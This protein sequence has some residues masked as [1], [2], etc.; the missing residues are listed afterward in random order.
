[1]V[2]ATRVAHR[3][4]RRPDADTRRVRRLHEVSTAVYRTEPWQFKRVLA[5]IEHCTAREF[6]REVFD[7]HRGAHRVFTA[8]AFLAAYLL[9][10]PM[11]GIALHQTNVTAVVRGWTTSQRRSLGLPPPCGHH[12]QERQRCAASPAVG[13]PIVPLSAVGRTRLRAGSPRCVPVV[14]SADRCRRPGFD[15]HF[16]VGEGSVPQTARRRRPR[17]GGATARSSAGAPRTRSIPPMPVAAGIISRTRR[18]ARTSGTSTRS[19]SPLEWAGVVPS[20]RRPAT[21]AG[22]TSM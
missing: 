22:M 1:M 17:R 2:R 5:L 8:D 3:R 19:I 15:G 10:P 4:H 9:T 14:L 16:D 13:V 11:L 7:H 21:S 20:S 12:V 18:S 6:V